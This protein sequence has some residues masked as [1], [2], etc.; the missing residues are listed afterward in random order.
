MSLSTHAYSPSQADADADADADGVTPAGIP[1]T[2]TR[3]E[4]RYVVLLHRYVCLSHITFS[5]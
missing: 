2:M 4:A 1:A 5:Y 3:D